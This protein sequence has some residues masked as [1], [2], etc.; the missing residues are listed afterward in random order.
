MGGCQHTHSL[1]CRGLNHH[2][3]GVKLSSLRLY[4]Y[5]F[6]ACG[7]LLFTLNRHRFVLITFKCEACRGSVFKHSSFPAHSYQWCCNRAYTTMVP[8]SFLCHLLSADRILVLNWSLAPPHLSNGTAIN[9]L[10]QSVM[11]VITCISACNGA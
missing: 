3:F 2:A 1:G 7:I 11:Q 10:L 8:A 4:I 5:N 6:I 9:I